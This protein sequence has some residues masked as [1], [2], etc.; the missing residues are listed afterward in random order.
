MIEINLEVT[1]LFRRSAIWNTSKGTALA[2]ALGLVL[3]CSMLMAG[4]ASLIVG[5]LKGGSVHLARS[6]VENVARA[7][8][9]DAIMWFR[10]SEVQ[11]V[12][13]FDP[14]YDDS[15]DPTIGL[16]SSF[17][18]SVAEGVWGRYEVER[19]GVRDLSAQRGRDGNGAV[20]E[21]HTTGYIYE[22]KDPNKPFSSPPNKIIARTTMVGEINRITI[23]LPPSAIISYRAMQITL[24]NNVIVNGGDEGSGIAAVT[25][26]DGTGKTNI[27]GEVYG[28][29]PIAVIDNMD[30]EVQTVFGVTEDE[31]RGMCDY[32]VDDVDEL[33][34]PLPDMAFVYINGNASF[35]QKIPMTGGGLL[36]VNGNVSMPAGTGSEFRG[37]VYVKD[38]FS[39]AARMEITGCLVVRGSIAIT[40]GGGNSIITYDPEVLDALNK[41]ISQYRESI[42]VHVPTR[43]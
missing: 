8:F 34:N 25:H 40:G 42:S 15:E 35:S 27:H 20:W 5:S 33:P 21:I 31:L 13:A 29:P 36:F 19:T 11:P 4:G 6:Q 14:G 1:M 38:E 22:A 24:G 23:L 32:V 43:G 37:L 3:I 17:P 9:R 7:G 18:I 12:D 30:I 16:V 39:G 26:D 41:S 28:D 10:R 2:Y